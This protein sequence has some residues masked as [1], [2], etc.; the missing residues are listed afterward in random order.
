MGPGSGLVAAVALIMVLARYL[1]KTSLY[2]RFALMTMIPPGPSLAG[3][4]R[5]FATAL[6]VTLQNI[7]SASDGYWS[8]FTGLLRKRA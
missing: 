6:D 4:P 5:E 1:P 8:V 2:R 7:D 3:A